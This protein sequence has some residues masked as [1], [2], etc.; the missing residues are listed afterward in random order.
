MVGSLHHIGYL[1]DD[2]AVEAAR[3]CTDFGY[4]R[5]GPEFADAIQSARVCFLRQ[6]GA[7]HWLELITP[8]GPSGKLTNALRQ[9]VCLHHLCY[10]VPNV[11][12]TLALLREKGWLPLGN[13]EPAVA[14]GGRLVAWAMDRRKMLIELV[15]AGP[16]PYQL[17]TLRATNVRAPQS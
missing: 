14:F 2:L 7:D 15:E 8:V 10:E 3:W 6:P 9:Q 12:T 17:K 1:T 5:E 16:G 11:F 13:A 4:E